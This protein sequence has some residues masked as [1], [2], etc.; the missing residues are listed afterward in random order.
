[1]K[2]NY[3]MRLAAVLLVLVLLSTCVISGTFAKYVTDGSASDEA[4]VAQFGVVVSGAGN[5]MFA[6]E[7]DETGEVTVRANVDVVAPG[8]QGQLADFTIT[9][10]PEVKVAVNYTATLTLT[11]WDVSGYYCPIVITVNGASVYGTDYA[12]E[13]EFAAAVKNAVETVST[14][15]EVGEDLSDVLDISWSWAFEGNDDA[16]DTALGDASANGNA[17]TIKLEVT[18]TV[19]QIN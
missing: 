14:T 11:G 1:M 19:T 13:A 3:M 9:G 18:C 6:A 12:D 10:T 16:K 5:E 8:T 2:K 15:Y 4:R 17:A 7:Y